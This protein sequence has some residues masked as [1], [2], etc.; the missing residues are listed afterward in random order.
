MAHIK[1]GK[2]AKTNEGL[3][4]RAL[5]RET[6]ACWDLASALRALLACSPCRNGCAPSD[7]SCA[8]ARARAALR[9]AGFSLKGALSRKR[10]CVKEGGR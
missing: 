10:G 4:A 8:G 9:G 3:L 1:E 2:A 7:M 5:Q 6:V